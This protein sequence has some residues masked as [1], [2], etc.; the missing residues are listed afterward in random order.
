MT[1][2]AGTV[3][4]AEAHDPY[5]GIQ[6]TWVNTFDP[7]RKFSDKE[8]DEETGLD[9]FGAR[10]YSAPGWA[11]GHAS[12]SYRWLSLDPVLD[13]SKA[14]A[15]S[16]LWNF[17]T[18]SG[19]NPISN[20]DP[21]GRAVISFTLK[22]TFASSRD[23]YAWT[24]KLSRD[25]AL[26]GNFYAKGKPKQNSDGTWSVT[27]AISV[28]AEVLIPQANDPVYGFQST[29]PKNVDEVINHEIGCHLTDLVRTFKRVVAASEKLEQ[30]RFG[31]ENEATSAAGR[32]NKDR[33]EEICLKIAGFIWD[34]VLPKGLHYPN[35]IW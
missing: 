17:Y 5:G 10:Y 7:K 29:D 1:D 31:S 9:Y 27:V 11:D 4:Y 3:V 30:M 21:D 35:E 32:F 24:G 28:S 18:Y 34:K 22:I 26:I 14:I 33:N 8:R 6:K 23:N 13:R 19:N 20:M 25:G 16:Q 2:D 12:G 15:N